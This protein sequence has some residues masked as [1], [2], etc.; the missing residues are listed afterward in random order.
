MYVD[1]AVFVL[2]AEAVRQDGHKARK[3]G[4]ADVL[5]AQQRVERVC[6]AVRAVKIP[7]PQ[8]GR[9]DIRLCGALERIGVRVGRNDERNA[10]VFDLPR[11]LR[12]DQRL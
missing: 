5:I 3:H 11:L 1:D 9:G 2:A 8:Y 7:A 4:K 6:V 10:P 12:V